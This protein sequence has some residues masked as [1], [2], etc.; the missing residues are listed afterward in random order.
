MHELARVRPHPVHERALSKA[1]KKPLRKFSQFN[2]AS[3]PCRIQ[4]DSGVQTAA[5]S[6]SSKVAEGQV[7]LGD[8]SPRWCRRGDR[9]PAPTPNRTCKFPSHPALQTV[10]I[11]E[12][13]SAVGRMLSQSIADFLC[14]RCCWDFP[15]SSLDH[16][17]VHREPSRLVNPSV[18]QN[19]T[20][21]RPSPC[22][23]LSQPRT[24]TTAPPPVRL[25]GENLNRQLSVWLRDHPTR[26]AS[27]VPLLVL[28]HP[29]L[30][31]DVWTP[32]S[33][34]LLPRTFAE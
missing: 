13:L 18:V 5:S 2:T 34:L 25:I 14:F 10:L 33:G 26:T 20:S 3:R 22:G 1:V 19:D 29:R 4:T 16:F 6:P 15:Q 30:G 32:N 7:A 9:T 31:F 11:I 21:C 23:W 8:F 24:T 27:L 28:K 12:N 17:H